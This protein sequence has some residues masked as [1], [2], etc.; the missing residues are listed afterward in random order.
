MRRILSLWQPWATLCVARDPLR[1]EV[2]KAIETRSWPP[3]IPTPF[4]VL[5]HATAGWNYEQR[6]YCKE[7]PVIK[8]LNARNYYSGDPKQ[9]VLGQQLRPLPL[10]CIVGIATVKEVIPT[11]DPALRFALTEEESYFGLFTEGRYAWILEDQRELGVPIPHRGRQTA[12]LPAPPELDAEVNRDLG[13]TL[14][15]PA[16]PEQNSPD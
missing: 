14:A 9:A 13:I 3:K 16:H 8:A 12:L 11:N 7:L 1:N 2:A 4:E 10:G 15:L 5:I 6:I